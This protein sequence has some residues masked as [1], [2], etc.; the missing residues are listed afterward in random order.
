MRRHDTTIQPDALARMI[1]HTF[2]KSFG[3]PSDIERICA[4]AVEYGF[5]IVAVNPAEV[6]NCVKLLRNSEVGVGAAIGFPLG[7]N[8]SETKAFETRDAI[9]KGA[10]EIDTVINIRALQA[11]HSDIVFREIAE[12]VE[13][14]RP[15][16]VIS[17]VILETC[18][19]SNEDKIA[20]CE[21]AC[22]AGV[23]F[24][25]TSTGFGKAGATLDDVEL[26]RRICGPAMGIKASGG[27]RDL[28]TALSMVHAGA[29]RI[30]TSS[31]V[32]ILNE[33]NGYVGEAVF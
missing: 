21:M 29:T 2:L 31:G 19:L 4:E 6:E 1:D 16:G 5:A 27:V 24:V 3:P 9:G 20:V 28:E 11:G 32:A 10:T 15:A 13:I 17:K 8:T 25:K 26:I 22:R 12:M 18:Y 30:G 33:L 7:Q 23:D 14:C